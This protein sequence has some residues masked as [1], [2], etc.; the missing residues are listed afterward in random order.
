MRRRLSLGLLALFVALWIVFQSMRKQTTTKD[1]KAKSIR[2]NN[3]F[4]IIQP[5]PDKW[6]GL[7]GSDNG[8][9]IFESPVYGVRAGFINLV[10]GYL[11]KGLNTINKI[12]P[13]YAPSSDGNNPGAYA[14]AVSKFTGI[15]SDD[16]IGP[17]Q[18]YPIGRAIERIE[19]GRQWVDPE[20]FDEGYKMALNEVGAWFRSP[21]WENM[22]AKHSK[23]IKAVKKAIANAGS[24][25]L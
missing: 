10:N 4:A 25:P 8:F 2:N 21:G 7:K 19:A 6:R 20:D 14:A 5:V 12:F 9:L 1:R 11:K 16:L 3:P 18:V 24:V 17:A 23:E 13:V 22:K 15:N